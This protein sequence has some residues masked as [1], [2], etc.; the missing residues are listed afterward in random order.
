MI[1]GD[2]TWGP[3]MP[4]KPRGPLGP[5]SPWEKRQRWSVWWIIQWMTA[6]WGQSHRPPSW[7]QSAVSF[8]LF[9]NNMLETQ[10]PVHTWS[11]IDLSHARL[12]NYSWK[13]RINLLPAAVNVILQSLAVRTEGQGK[14]LFN[15]ISQEE[16]FYFTTTF[17]SSLV[18]NNVMKEWHN[19]HIHG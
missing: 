11:V 19:C 12:H 7:R 8:W 14:D 9:T 18:V 13:S 17:S 1:W 6:G 2:V 5:G 3:T 15:V 4:G 10:S 16:H